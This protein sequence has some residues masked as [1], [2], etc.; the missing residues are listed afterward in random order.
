MQADIGRKQRL[1]AGGVRCAGV[2]AMAL[3]AGL[4]AAEG[5][6]A[7]DPIKPSPTRWTSQ[8]AMER[9]QQIPRWSER[10]SMAAATMRAGPIP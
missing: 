2:P 8:G 3:L 10:C 4:L 5:A 9:G 1:R 6:L 7:A